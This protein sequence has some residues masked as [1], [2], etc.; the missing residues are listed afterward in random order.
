MAAAKVFPSPELAYRIPSALSGVVGV[1]LVMLILQHL[2]KKPQVT[3][4]GGLIFL[5]S[6]MF[7]DA[8]RQVRLDAPVTVM[9]LL[10]F[11]CFIRG[12][13]KPIWFLGMGVGVALAILTK[14]VIGLLAGPLFLIW[15]IVNWDFKWLKSLY[16][17]LG[18]ILTFL[19][20]L[21]WHLYEHIKFGSAFWSEYLGQHVVHRF[22]SN[23]L[24]GT[25]AGSNFV[26]LDHLF[27]FALPWT[28][29]FAIG[30]FILYAKRKKLA[31]YRIALA[32]G[33]QALFVL[34]LFFYAGTKLTYYLTPA[35]PFMA[36]FIAALGYSLFASLSKPG[37]K[38]VF[39]CVFYIILLIAGINTI[40]VGFRYN[41]RLQ[42]NHI[43]SEDEKQIGLALLKQP[44][45]EV[46]AYDYP[47]RDTILYY[48]GRTMQ[49]ME[50]DQ[51]LDHPFFL[52][53]E[54]ALYD[55]SPFPPELQDHFTPVFKGRA[56]ILLRFDL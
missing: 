37:S 5:T 23:I 18:T 47:Y 13:E 16:F 28:V 50:Q 4:F 39:K 40:L 30:L 7:I 38:F 41:E 56:V 26:Y 42:M 15:A 55:A 43:V 36:L 52:V 25:T 20:I 45:L 32:F 34:A 33:L 54:S 17:W 12:S 2:I 46:Y 35:Y 48:S 3:F 10:A 51:I 14:S 49:T 22:N 19:I 31:N 9:I 11:Y 6:P 53:I 29:V 1:L 44:P 21:P 8:A 27:S 24:G